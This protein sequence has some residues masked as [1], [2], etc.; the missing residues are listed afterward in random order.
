MIICFTGEKGL[1]KLRANSAA[2][3][4]LAFLLIQD[5]LII[6]A[7]ICVHENFSQ[8]GAGARG[9]HGKRERKFI[10]GVWGGALSGVQGQR[11]W[12]GIHRQSPHE[13][14][15]FEAFVHTFV[16]SSHPMDT[17]IET[18][19]CF[20][21][22]SRSPSRGHNTNTRDSYSYLKKIPK[23][24]YPRRLPPSFPRGGICPS[25]ISM[26]AYGLYSS[27]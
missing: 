9:C 5:R 20:V 3:F 24:R 11:F 6:R 23:L 12:S 13:A 22:R 7:Y 19:N 18:D 16:R 21:M 10:T 2:F 1:A 14:E 8:E 4:I 27:S 15:S 25:P 26:G 17:G